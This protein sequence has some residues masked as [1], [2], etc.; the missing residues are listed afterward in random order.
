MPFWQ[1][2]LIAVALG[3]DAFTVGFA[4]GMKFQGF[5]HVLRLAT[6]FGIFQFGMYIIG[7]VSGAGLAGVFEH[8]GSYISA[9]ILFAV[10]AHMIHTSFKPLHLREGNPTRGAQLIFLSIATSVD[11]LAVG[12]GFGILEG[13]IYLPAIIIGAAAFAMTVTGMRLGKTFS[14]LVGKEAEI[15]AG[16]ILIFLGIKVL[17]GK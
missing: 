10:A 4:V 11:A 16:I 14:K 15:L 2:I 5:Y 9:A 13:R 8:Y 12:I 3:L 7:K 17:L 6:S 1:I